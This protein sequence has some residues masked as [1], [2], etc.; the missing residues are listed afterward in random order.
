MN[1]TQYTIYWTIC[2]GKTATSCNT[3]DLS[4]ALRITEG[5][6]KNP[7]CSRIAWCSENVD[8]VGNPGVDSIK[9][10]KTPDGEEYTWVKRRDG[11]Q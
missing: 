10:G 8:Q 11:G 7:Q 4:E 3:D 6:R 2:D 1:K 9:D 5:L